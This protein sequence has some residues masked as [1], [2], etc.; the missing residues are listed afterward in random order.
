MSCKNSTYSGCFNS[1]GDSGNI[2]LLHFL[3][4]FIEIMCC[5][6]LVFVAA[7]QQVVL[8]ESYLRRGKTGLCYHC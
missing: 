6:A 2:L 5:H 7:G 8:E 1:K 4:T 3:G